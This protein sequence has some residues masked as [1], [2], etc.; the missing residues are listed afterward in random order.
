MRR[1]LALFKNH[2]ANNQALAELTLPNH[3]NYCTKWGYDLLIHTCSYEEAAWGLWEHF[4]AHL[5]NYDIIVSIGSD[6]LFTNYDKPLTDFISTGHAVTLGAE[7]INRCGCPIN[8]DLMIWHNSHQT[9]ELIDWSINCEKN[10]KSHKWLTQGY[11]MDLVLGGYKGINVLPCRMLQSAPYKNTP[12]EWQPGDFSL[13]FL[14]MDNNR[15]YEGCKAFL[16]N[17]T[18]NWVE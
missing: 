5:S 1:K 14:G 15:K 6:V 11:W 2:S 17:K 9:N 13:H 7:N 16:E 10:Y 8:A 3:F 18:I 12:M 4:R